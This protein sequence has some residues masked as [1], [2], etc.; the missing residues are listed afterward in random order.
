MACFE[1]LLDDVRIR[2]FELDQDFLQDLQQGP[3][4]VVFVVKLHIEEPQEQH[5]V[6][7]I[8]YVQGVARVA[9]LRQHLVQTVKELIIIALT[10]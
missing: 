5:L 7:V 3:I 10:I 9:D 6:F 8:G 4:D 2:E 1:A